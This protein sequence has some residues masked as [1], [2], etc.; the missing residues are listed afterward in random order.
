[1]K[2][3]AVLAGQIDN[4]SIPRYF[5]FPDATSH[6]I[7]MS[8]I[9]S[10]VIFAKTEFSWVGVVF[11]AFIIWLHWKSPLA[12]GK[13]WHFEDMTWWQL[14]IVIVLLIAFFGMG[15]LSFLF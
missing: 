14:L 5:S 3:L 15:V 11:V 4:S 9:D 7:T 6:S 10:T 13:T 1:M 2:A 12:D 8:L